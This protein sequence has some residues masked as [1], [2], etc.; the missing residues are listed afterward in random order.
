MNASSFIP[1]GELFRKRLERCSES[2]PV[3]SVTLDKGLVTRNSLDR[4]QETELLPG[5]HL[6][7]KKDDLVYNMMRMWQGA[8]GVAPHDGIVS[9]AYVVLAPR[10]SRVDPG[11]AS[12]LFKTQKLLHCFWS[13]SYGITDDRLR[14]YY[15]DFAKIKV[16]LP[17]IEYQRR[18]AAA[19]R[20]I[21]HTVSLYSA[22][23]DATRRLKQYFVDCLFNPVFADVGAAGVKDRPL[24]G[25][26]VRLA[27]NRFEPAS[28]LDRPLCIELDDLLG[29]LG[30]L[31]GPIQPVPDHASAKIRFRKGDILYGKLRPYLRKFLLP[32]FEGVCS[33]EI[34]VLRPSA[35]SVLPAFVFYLVQTTKFSRFANVAT[36]SKMP[37]AEWSMVQRIP[38]SLPEPAVQQAIVS[39]LVVLDRRIDC[40]RTAL[41][42]SE[43]LK[44]GILS[45]CLEKA[46]QV[47]TRG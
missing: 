8:S 37:R 44:E 20:N 6:L 46:V 25:D 28:E 41:K 30:A 36:G 43:G 4:K 12:Y 18:V 27:Q 19:L 33:S 29:E 32:S 13:Q 26:S 2:L 11:F 40:L 5:E 45:E 47:C 21:D 23:I 16:S 17:T 34:W 24:F 35:T 39:P 3:L 38:L 7:A 10:T 9:P 14:L 15:K 1:L 31:R 22:L 42:E